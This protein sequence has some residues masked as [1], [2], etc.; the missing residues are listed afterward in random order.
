MGQRYGSKSLVSNIPEHEFY[1]ILNESKNIS[2]KENSEEILKLLGTF[3]E[4]DDNNIVNKEYKLKKLA[5]VI[6]ELKVCI[7]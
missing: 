2:I 6:D 3:Y 5:Q 1:N 7:Q 4:L